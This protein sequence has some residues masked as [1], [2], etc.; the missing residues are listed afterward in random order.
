MIC[1][2]CNDVELHE[3]QVMNALSRTTRGAD[4]VPVYVCPPCGTGEAMNEYFDGGTEPQ[5]EWPVFTP[6]HEQVV[7]QISKIG[8]SG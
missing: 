1:P 8:G 6:R 5:S 3:E 7:E 4:D 2:R